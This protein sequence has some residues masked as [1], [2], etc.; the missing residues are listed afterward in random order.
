MT[1]VTHSETGTA[2][3]PARANAISRD[4][5][6]D[7][8]RGIAILMVIGIHALQQPLDASW[9]IAL[10]AFLRPCVPIFLFASGY[11]TGLSGRVP[12]AKRITATVIPYAIAFV[13]AYAYMALMNPAM[14]HRITTTIARF[15]LAYVFVYYYVF[16]YIGCT[17]M[18][19]LVL[20][21]A[22]RVP[23]Q[24]EQRLQVLL[25]I[26]IAFGLIVGSYLD[27]TLARFGLSDGSIEEF[28]MR[29]I[30]F[31]FGFAALGMLVAR[32]AIRDVLLD[33]M[34]TLAVATVGAYAIYTGM[35]ISVIGDAAAYDSTA[36]F[37]YAA[38]LSVFLLAMRADVPLLATLGRG[39]ISSISGIS[40]SSWRCAI[41][42]ASA[43]SAAWLPRY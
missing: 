40:S 18:L 19:W 10:D 43:R 8:M 29:D 7:T 13:A 17:L 36:F 6:I 21:F 12:V 39:A 34:P 27:P 22:T 28:R 37:G 26:A 4:G 14:D 30:P 38:A 9:K 24:A 2:T 5:A 25:L 16:V 15:G 33:M 20:W 23:Q 11:L 35:R 42:A 1:S 41:S 32:A 3:A 31:W